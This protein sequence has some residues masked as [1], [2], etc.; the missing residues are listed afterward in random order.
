LQTD[1]LNRRPFVRESHLFP[2]LGLSA[3]FISKKKTT[4]LLKFAK[5]LRRDGPGERW[6]ELDLD[7]P[8]PLIWEI[9]SNTLGSLAPQIQEKASAISVAEAFSNSLEEDRKE[10]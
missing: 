2:L 1:Q 6:G 3:N 8:T 4:S 7:F 5:A 9:F 10:E